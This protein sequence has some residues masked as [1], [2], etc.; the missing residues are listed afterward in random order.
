MLEL[1]SKQ[2]MEQ[3]LFCKSESEILTRI[4]PLEVQKHNILSISQY[5]E[6]TKSAFRFVKLYVNWNSFWYR[7]YE[8]EQN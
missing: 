8:D 5:H 3:A 6:L 7:F 2:K 4:Q 1:E